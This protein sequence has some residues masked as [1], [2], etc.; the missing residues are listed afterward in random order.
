[1]KAQGIDPS[2]AKQQAKATVG[3][4]ESSDSICATVSLPVLQFQYA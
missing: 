1:M 3:N 4:P 2:Q